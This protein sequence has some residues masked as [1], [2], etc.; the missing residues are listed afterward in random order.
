LF[1]E[2]KA[3]SIPEKNAEKIIERS[4]MMIS[5]SMKEF[6]IYLFELFLFSIF[7]LKYLLKKKTKVI[8]IEAPR[9]K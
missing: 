6:I 9:N 5:I 8:K 4:I 2:T 7:F 3:I 1:A